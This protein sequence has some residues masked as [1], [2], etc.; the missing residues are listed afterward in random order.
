MTKLKPQD[1]HDFYHKTLMI[2]LSV[3]S[4]RKAHVLIM[5]AL[6]RA[7]TWGEIPINVASTVVLPQ[8]KKAKYMVWNEQQLKIFLDAAAEDQ[9]FTA[10]EL[11][12]ST[13]MRQSEIL[14][15]GWRD[16]RKE[17]VLSQYPFP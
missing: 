13:G 8:G 16:H 12:S 17:P 5:D 2:T 10:F 3:G 4:I 15:L 1:L 14:A 6:N 9:Y 7:V 11:A